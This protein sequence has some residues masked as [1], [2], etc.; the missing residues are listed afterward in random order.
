MT[1]FGTGSP[2]SEPL[3]TQLNQTFD[4]GQYQSRYH[5]F[6]GGLD[7]SRPVGL[8]IFADGSGGAGFTNP[9]SSYQLDADGQDGLVAVARKHNLV[10]VTPI[11]PPPGCDS[12]DSARAATAENANCW[13]DRDN[14]PGKAQWSSD[15]LHHVKSQLKIQ[16]SRVV[17]G[18]YSSG[19]QWATQF[20]A[21]A[22]AEEHSVD[23]TVAI[24]YGG[25]PAT[26]PRFSEAFKAQTAFA[27][28]TG[29]ADNAYRTDNYG[30]VGGYNWYTG[31]GFTT[32][33][34]WPEGVDH[35]RPGQ[36]GQIMDREITRFLGG[37]S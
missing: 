17:V 29:T 26:T 23:L 30:S 11:A 14:A 21:P 22:H 27:W 9:N 2:A 24:G 25:A 16:P 12:G 34:T 3:Y 28:E 36:F 37:T 33:A 1:P 15:L 8:M 13:Y 5:V 18:G 6:A 19:A 7:P 20:F 35:S 32:Q 10:L 4:N 31:N